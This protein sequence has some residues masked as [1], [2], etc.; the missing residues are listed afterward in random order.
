[1]AHPPGAAALKERGV[2]GQARA[3]E[4]VY[5]MQA[6]PAL[7]E[8]A[9]VCSSGSV[10]CCP[11]W[12][13]DKLEVADIS[14]GTSVPRES[15]E[16]P[17]IASSPRSTAATRRRRLITLLP[18]ADLM[19]RTFPA[20]TGSAPRRLCPYKHPVGPPHSRPDPL[21]LLRRDLPGPLWVW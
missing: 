2:V 6:S 16:M 15:P 20:R 21:F 7:L 11:E 19:P 4:A 8:W 9:G 13:V 17:C 5:G 10:S 3:P 12:E 14:S 18:A 1:M